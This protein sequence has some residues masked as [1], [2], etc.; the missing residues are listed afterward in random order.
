MPHRI[1]SYKDFAMYV[2]TKED[3]AFA[4]SFVDW[5]TLAYG[6]QRI[7]AVRTKDG[8]L[9]LTEIEDISEVLYLRE[10]DEE[11]R[12][13]VTKQLVQSIKETFDN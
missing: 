9:L 2:P 10:M 12:D 7:D 8:K 6:I 11:N 1:E 5:N 3:L 13:R 4:Q